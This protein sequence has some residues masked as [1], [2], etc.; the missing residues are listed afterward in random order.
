LEDI[1]LGEKLEKFLPFRTES[2]FLWGVY[3]LILAL[4]EIRT[5]ARPFRYVSATRNPYSEIA[6]EISR[7]A[8]ANNQRVS[9]PDEIDQIDSE[10]VALSGARLGYAIL[11][12]GIHVGTIEGVPGKLEHIAVEPH[13]EGKGIA[14]AALQEFISLSRNHGISEVI[15]N[16]A[17]H[18]AMEHILETEGFEE[19]AED[20]G[21][22]RGT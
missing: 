19:R 21:W 8:N 2:G 13:W 1:T 20:I 16:N 11:V 12:D 22:K 9:D 4:V 10:D 5:Q 6:P 3:I 18:P 15:V 14:R 7:A 17:V